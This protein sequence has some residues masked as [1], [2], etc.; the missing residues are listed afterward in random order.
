MISAI[1]GSNSL[2][3]SYMA[4]M[5]QQMFN[6]IDTNGDGKHSKEEISAMAANGPKGGPSV[7]EIFSRADTDGDGYISQTE[8]EA[9]SPPDQQMQGS[10]FGGMA[11]VSSADF[12]QQMFNK[13]D[14]DGDG[15]HSKEEISAMAANGPKG[16][17]SVD[18]IFSRAD[19]DG[20]GYISQ[21]EFEADQASMQKN[22]PGQTESATQSSDTTDSLVKKLLE[23]LDEAAQTS[24][25][26]T[27]DK[28]QTNNSV[29]GIAQLLSNALKVYTQTSVNG[30]SQDNFAQGLL[31]SDLYA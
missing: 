21:A 23:A 24:T 5:R 19:T 14:T 25:S 15:K 9:D 7:D 22:G 3:Q 8:F 12:L 11:S 10:G 20:D 18:E 28:S 6:K 13:I 26:T 31:G 1:S 30:F 16:G 17:P 27:G 2:T 4:Q 29:A